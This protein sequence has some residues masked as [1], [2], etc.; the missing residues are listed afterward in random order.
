MSVAL[1]RGSVPAADRRT[2][3]VPLHVEWHRALAYW[4]FLLHPHRN[5]Q[6]EL[7]LFAALGGPGFGRTF[8]AIRDDPHVQVLLAE[9]PDL[10]K[11]V[12]DDDFLAS[13]PDGSLGHGLRHFLTQFRLDAGVF[14]EVGTI[15][16]LAQRLGYSDEFTYIFKRGVVM[17]DLYHVLGGYGPDYGGEFGNIGFHLG[18]M[19]GGN[20]FLNA[21]GQIMINLPGRPSRARRRRYWD[22]AVARGRNARNI[23]ASPMEE[24]L[25]LPIDEV[26]ERLGIA[27]TSVAHPAGHL[28]IPYPRYLHRDPQT[29]WSYPA[30]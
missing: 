5:R 23:I 1:D 21:L 24:L 6:D 26:R 9:R 28:F 12:S 4:Q 11:L 15:D 14:D 7:G 19:A 2:A 10:R 18:Q 29:P 16:P 20:G 25:A 30:R 3:G 8:L 13:L 17:H 27:P 22:E